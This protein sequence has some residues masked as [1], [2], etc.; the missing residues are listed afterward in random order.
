MTTEYSDTTRKVLVVAYVFPPVGGGGV[1]RTH[2]FVK[3][4][5]SFGWQP[6]VLT[7][8]H[9]AFDYQDQTLGDEVDHEVQV[10]KTFSVEPPRLYS[11]F[12]KKHFGEYSANVP[13]PNRP[14]FRSLL[15][16]AT[17][18]PIFNLLRWS[19]HNLVFVP[20]AHV[21]WIP[22]AVWRGLR[23]IRSERIDIIY[24][25]GDPYSDFLIGLFLSRLTG[26]PLV[27]DMRDPWTLGPDIKFSRAR[28]AIENFW[29]RR[30]VNA[31]ATVIN[32]TEAATQA[33]REKFAN[34]DPSKF[35]C[36]TQGFDP[37]DFD[38]VVGGKTEKF[39]IAATGTYYEFR[40]PESFLKALRSLVDEKPWLENL[41][42]V[43][44][45]GVG[46]KIVQH[47]VAEYDLA[48]VVEVL[49]YGTHRESIQLLMDSDVL[50]LDFFASLDNMEHLGSTSSRVFEYIGSGRPI[51]G[52]VYPSGAAADVINSTRSGIVVDPRD[53]PQ[54]A[55]AIHSLFERYQ[56]GEGVD[57]LPFNERPNLERFTRKHLTGSLAHIMDDALA[58]T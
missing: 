47:F 44:F 3:Y 25:T 57:D 9:A 46:E 16:A 53:T 11:S 29:E 23:V 1:Q 40:T 39:T 18:K 24:A 27:L 43:R 17:L 42:Q 52:L 14:S 48:A 49:P 31:A 5:P 2:K 54:V 45:M 15:I 19:A 10:Y 8:K 58:T 33:Y 35:V 20:D 51:L 7:P 50:L 4:L 36:I 38:D 6:V 13:Q 55:A 26:K 34:A 30:C 37:T 12:I 32:I 41:L 22:F 21:G 28:T 56:S